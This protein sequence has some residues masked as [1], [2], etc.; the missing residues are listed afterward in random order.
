MKILLVT[1]LYLPSVNGVVTSVLNLARVLR[2]R[3]HEVRILTLSPIELSYSFADVYYIGSVKIPVYQDIHASLRIPTEILEDILAWHPDIVHSNCEF[4]TFS[5]A[6]T[7]SKKA[8]VP[9][10]HTYHTMY[11]SYVRYVRLRESWGEIATGKFVRSRLGKV[12]H[13]VAPTRKVAESLRGF[14]LSGKIHVVPTGIDLEMFRVAQDKEKILGLRKTLG[15]E[16]DAPVLVSVGRLA[17]EKNCAELIENMAKIV[18]WNPRVMLLFV[19]DGPDRSDLEHLADES[20]LASNIV[21]AGMVDPSQVNSHYRVGDLFVAA[22]RSETQGLTYIEALASGIP[23]VCRKD[24]CIEDVVIDGKN[25]FTYE[26]PDEYC[27]AIRRLLEDPSSYAAMKEQARKSVERFSLERFGADM[28]E[29]Y[30]TC[31]AE[32]LE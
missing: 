32:S 5:F 22:S 20:G 15:I 11:E 16:E 27:T 6:R 3:G 21:F 1:D 13:L 12:R 4:F 9:L 23:V 26:Q 29:I 30:R 7:V 14:G 18:K 10:V 19:G 17:K 25:G 28:E 8:R 2:Q 31:I 24:K